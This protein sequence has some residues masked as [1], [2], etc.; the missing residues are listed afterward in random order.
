[1][2]CLRRLLVGLVAVLIVV[3]AGPARSQSPEQAGDA[4]PFTIVITQTVKVG[5]STALEAVL[6][7]L[8]ARGRTTPGYVGAQVLRPHPDE[9]RDGTYRVVLAF[10]Q[11]AAWDLWRHAAATA[12][13]Q[14]RLA[15][16]VQG[17]VTVQSAAGAESWFTPVG[18]SRLRAPATLRRTA[19]VW[20]VVFPLITGVSMVTGPFLTGT[21]VV[22]RSL[23][24]TAVMVPTMTMVVFPWVTWTFQDWLY[25]PTER[26]TP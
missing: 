7:E 16:T 3:A 10:A 15:A 26:C 9:P 23:I 19:L 6:Q 17:P 25:H 14:R 13:L 24:T 4:G 21:P 2:T 5:C 18:N 1:M 8:L 22:V 12:E 11:P 20:M